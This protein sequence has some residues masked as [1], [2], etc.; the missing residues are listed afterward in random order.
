MRGRVLSQQGLGIIGVRV[1]VDRHP[2]LG[3]TLTRQGG[4][5]DILVNGGG[6][7]TLQFQRNPYRPEMRTVWAAWNRIVVLDS[8]VL[9]LSD[10]SEPPVSDKAAKLSADKPQCKIDELE[11]MRPGVIPAQD[12]E[13]HHQSGDGQKSYWFVDKQV[14]QEVV[15]L[16]GLPEYKLVYRS[17]N[18]PSYHSLLKLQLTPATGVPPQLGYIHVR[19]V[20]EG[21]VTELALETDANLTHTFAWDRHNVYGQRIYGRTDAYVHVGY[22][23]TADGCPVSWH[24]LVAPMAGFA[25]NI[26]AIGEFNVDVHHH[27]IAGQNVLFRGDGG[28]LDLQSGPRQLSLLIGTGSPRS[29]TCVECQAASPSAYGKILNPVAM[30]AAGDGSIYVGDFNLVRKVTP[31]GRVFTVLQLPNGQVSYSYYLAV[32]PIDGTLYLSD[33]ERKQILRIAAVSEEQILNPSSP[34]SVAGLENNFEVVVGSGEPC[35]PADPEM[36][37]DGRPALEARLVFPKGVAVSSDRI[38][39]FADGTAI[40]YV[41]SA[42]IIRTLVGR[43]ASPIFGLHPAPC[44]AAVRPSQVTLPIV[45]SCLVLYI[46]CYLLFTVRFFLADSTFVAYASGAQSC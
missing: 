46:S 45:H 31:E 20:V 37:G 27:F 28:Q 7:V 23:A 32:S 16:P 2:R 9:R 41:D 4:W 30:A 5:F 13:F 36:C 18:A 26:S 39:Y 11:M 34:P 35:L 3:F 6:A 38:L 40:R 33:N 17:E 21:T 19:V 25:P 12:A 10:S 1:S 24:T 44:N 29:L 15:P 14:L 8:V 22:Q 42:G 43:P